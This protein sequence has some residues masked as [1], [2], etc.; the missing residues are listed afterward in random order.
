MKVQTM[1]EREA[2]EASAPPV[3]PDGEYDCEI[4]VAVEKQSKSSGMWMFE[5]D[6][7]IL[8][9]NDKT[10]TVRDW[11]MTEGKAAWRL[12]QFCGAFDLMA[13]YEA[14]NINASDMERRS[15][16]VSLKTEPGDDQYGPKNRIKAYLAVAS[17]PTPR[18]RPQPGRQPAMAA[19]TG[20]DLGDD[21]IPFSPEWR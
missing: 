10:R 3:L 8:L 21:D 17:A 11:V 13:E 16:R 7:R 1:T 9:D 14:G 2:K 20:A 4:G 5:I 15:G 6:I 19:S 18:P 12:R